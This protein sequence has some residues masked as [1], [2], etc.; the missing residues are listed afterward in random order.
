MHDVIGKVAESFSNTKRFGYISLLHFFNDDAI[1][2]GRNF[3]SHSNNLHFHGD[4]SLSTTSWLGKTF[5]YI[6]IICWCASLSRGTLV[7]TVGVK[8]KSLEAKCDEL[9][10]LNSNSLINLSMKGIENTRL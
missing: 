10:N 5:S 1:V 9:V 7:I 2:F 8:N 3:S 6:S 4:S